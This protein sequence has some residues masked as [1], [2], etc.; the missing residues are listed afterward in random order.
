[1]SSSSSLKPLSF[2]HAFP[3]SAYFGRVVPKSKIYE[4]SLATTAVKEMFVKEVNK[5]IWKYKLSS[6]TINLPSRGAI[7]EIQIFTVELKNGTLKQEVLRTIDRAIPS[8]IIFQLVFGNK[9]K[10]IA[11]YKR[12]NDADK[13]KSVISNYF[14]TD[15]VNQN[16]DQ[17]SLPVALDLGILY[18]KLLLNLIK[19][20][21][22]PHEKF[23]EFI[24]RL[25]I[26]KVKEKEL[27]KLNVQ[28][29][30]E[31]QYN[32]RVEL[33]RKFNVLKSEIRSLKDE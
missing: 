16:S 27:S 24:N 25:E 20:P 15:W 1:M 17:R 10:Y 31:K 12:P 23:K 8:P 19:E 6:K 32:R 4:K 26:L 33:N 22:R 30:K 28:I 9:F 21:I 13:S 5:I 2:I 29:K 7:Y 3:Q 11:A 14:E 18:E